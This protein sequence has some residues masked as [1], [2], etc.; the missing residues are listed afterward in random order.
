MRLGLLD[1]CPVGAEKLAHTPYKLLL[2]IIRSYIDRNATLADA[3][4]NNLGNIEAGL[5]YYRIDVG[6]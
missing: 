6:D 4:L 3:V 1:L 5:G 2:H